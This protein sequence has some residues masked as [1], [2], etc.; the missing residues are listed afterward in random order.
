MMQP[1]KFEEL[2]VGMIIEDLWCERGKIRECDDI[3]NIIVD[4]ENGGVSI[5]CFDNDC[6]DRDPTGLYK[7]N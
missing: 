6:D 5:Y 2:K 7:I 3:H 4:F 1:L